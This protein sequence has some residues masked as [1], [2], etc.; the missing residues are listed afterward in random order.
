MCGSTTGNLGVGRSGGGY[1]GFVVK[2]DPNGGK[3]WTMQFDDS[4]GDFADSIAVD[5]SGNFFVA[6]GNGGLDS[7][8]AKFDGNRNLLWRITPNFSSVAGGHTAVYETATDASGDLFIVGQTNALYDNGLGFTQSD[9]IIAKYGPGGNLLWERK[10]DRRLFD[11]LTSVALDS[12]GNVFVAGETFSYPFGLQGDDNSFWA[13]YDS[14]GNLLFQDEFGTFEND[15][16]AG[17]AVDHS[18]HVYVTGS[19]WRDAN[20]YYQA[21]GDTYLARFD[22]VVPEPTSGIL[23]LTGAF[24]IALWRARPAKLC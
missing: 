23:I 4:I 1:D 9:G 18:G 24:M 5:P 13:K 22:Q 2:Y 7:S 10:L 16:A 8:I 19:V 6:V 21:D 12:H 11:V 15:G 3:Q 20:G 14:A 17:I